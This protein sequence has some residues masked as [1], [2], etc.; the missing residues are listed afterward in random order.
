MYQGTFLHDLGTNTETYEP[1]AIKA[2]DMSPVNNEVTDYLLQGEKKAM[3][4]IQSPYVIKTL[5]IIQEPEYC[6]IV[7]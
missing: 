1:V 4:S 2:I 3:A 5:D 7:M 6:Y